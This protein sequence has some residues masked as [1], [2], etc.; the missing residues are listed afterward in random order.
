MSLKHSESLAEFAP[1]LIKLQGLLHTIAHDAE[2]EHHNLTYT[3]L[4]GIWKA[5]RQP[6][7]D[8]ELA[9]A[10]YIGEAV[11][12]GELSFMTVETM[13][14][15]KSGQFIFCAGQMPIPT[16]KGMNLSQCCGIAITYLKRYA[17]CAAL[18]ITT[19]DD[20][21]DAQRAW[22]KEKERGEGIKDDK[23]TWQEL[24]A[25][26]D[27][28]E[29][30]CPDS[31]DLLGDVSFK[32]LSPLMATNARAGGPNA[33][34]TAA[35]AAMVEGIC[36]NRGVTVAEALVKVEWTGKPFMEMEAKDLMLVYNAVF[37][38]IPRP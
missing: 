33:A 9:V 16:Q 11:S 27:W 4:D 34:L 38:K 25:S 36:K 19:G 20:D 32:Q 23:R 17:V 8:C 2:N 21:G 30:P 31:S 6:L 26:G 14:I 7:Q 1:A 35:T 37:A 15:H 3:T 10:Q 28:K 13:V 24:H 12:V 29:F 5:I 18:G 22:P